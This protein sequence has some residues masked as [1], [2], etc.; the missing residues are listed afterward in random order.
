MKFAL[1]LTLA[2]VALLFFMIG[3]TSAQNS[4]LHPQTRDNLST[5]MHGEAFAFAKYTLYAQHARQSGH[6]QLAQLFAR[7][8]R[9]E[10]LQHFAEEARL[11]GLIG[12]DADNL[13]D[14]VKGESYEIETMYPGF[15]KQAAAVGDKAAA[16][17]FEEIRHDEMGHLKAYQAAL[18]ALE[19]K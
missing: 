7:T 2:A 8:A 13:K 10:R 14:A 18:H 11:A 5:A 4:T 3:R 9:V 15:A 19:M 17:R 12:S 6:P 16:E 1:S